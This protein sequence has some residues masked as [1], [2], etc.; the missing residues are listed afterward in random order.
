MLIADRFLGGDLGLM[1]NIVYDKVLTQGDFVRNTGWRTLR[2]WDFSAEKTVPSVNPRA[3]AVSAPA[4][5]AALTGA[6]RT[7][8]DRQWFDYSPSV[9]RY[10]L[11]T[12]D[13]KRMSGEFTA[14]YKFSNEFNAFASFQRNKQDQM[15]ND[16]NY[17]TDF[18]DVNRLAGAGNLPTYNPN[19]SVLAA[20]TCVP[21]STTST[22]AGMVVA[23]HHVTE[24]NVGNC[25]GVAGQGGYNAFSTSA[26]DFNLRVDSYYRSGGFNWRSGAWDAEGLIAKTNSRYANDTNSIVL[27]QNV[28]GLRVT[29]D[30]MGLPHFTFPAAWDPNKASSYTRAEMQY[31]P[32]E[33]DSLENQ[34]KLDLRYRTSIPFISKLWMGVQGR[35]T[36]MTQ[37]NGGGYIINQGANLASAADDLDVQTANV[38]QIFNWDPLS[39][40]GTLRAPVVQSFVNSNF[41]E[42]WISSAQMQG[43]VE[44]IRSTSPDFLKGSGVSGF[45]ANWMA[46]NYQAA[47][48][49]FDTSKFNH[50]LVRQAPGR[51]G[52]IYP[53]IPAFDTE[54]RIRSAYLRADFQQELFG[55]EIDGNFGVRYTGTRTKST[56]LQ[57]N[58]RR[59]ERTPGSAT[60]DDRILSNAIVTRENKY[61]DYLPSFNAATW[62]MPDELVVRVGYGK[63]MSRPAIDRLS[64]AINCL[65]GSGR[66]QFGGDG[67]DDCSAGNPNLKPYRAANKDL[68]V[69]WYPNKDSQLSLA[70]FRKDIQTSI[71]PN[72]V[73]RADVFGDGKLWDVTTTINYEGAQTNGVELAG[74]TAFT[75][76]PGVLSGFGIDA[77]Y[78]RMSSK[79]AAGAEILNTLDGSVLTFPGMS[80][81]SYNI[82]LWYDKDKINA[83]LAYNFRDPFY[84]GGNDVNTGNPVFSEETAYLDAKFQY[85]FNDQI[86]FSIEGKNL[87]DERTLL[88]AGS[89][90]RPNELAWNGRRYYASLSYK[91]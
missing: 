85:R 9:P 90:L 1:A 31:R 42:S 79:Y 13:H 88:T 5:C 80:K 19:G 10:G 20:G 73:V 52:K 11:W 28:P 30:A 37:Y 87:T 58:R 36:R 40:V 12:R 64:P 41:S 35:E 6:D 81:N 89:T 61:H 82:G 57:L 39:T 72:V 46:P 15:L 68:S 63:V 53:Q 91:F 66:S 44:K 74:R 77:N 54:E 2:D 48:P 47:V 70:Y 69:E 22:P 4:G 16:R 14:Q 29:L 55:L 43:I 24:Y 8:C 71:M 51:D 34:V 23:N 76:L 17:G 3:N 59:V 7:A 38:N 67:T 45:P 18:P 21:V 84:T 33:S 86:T 25:I 75:F 56:G 65:E 26:R 50:D 62:L 60:F 49:L 83:R 27:T 32:T 78:T